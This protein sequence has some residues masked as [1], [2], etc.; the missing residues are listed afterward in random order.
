MKARGPGRNLNSTTGDVSRRDFSSMRLAAF[1]PFGTKRLFAPSVW[2]TISEA[3]WRRLHWRT[4]ARTTPRHGNASCRPGPLPCYRWGL[5]CTLSL[6][7]SVPHAKLRSPGG[8]GFANVVWSTNIKH[9]THLLELDDE[10]FGGAVT[11]AFT[12]PP[13]VDVPGSS[14]GPIS[15]LLR[16]VGQMVRSCRQLLHRHRYDAPVCVEHRAPTAPNVESASCRLP[17][18]PLSR[19]FTLRPSALR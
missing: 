4:S 14:G 5:V 10:Q 16:G 18:H 6:S 7:H 19:W 9:A 11:E 2:T 17:A 13:P 15:G 12:R 3:S 8:A 1:L